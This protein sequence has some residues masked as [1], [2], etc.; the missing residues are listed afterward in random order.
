[1]KWSASDA[2]MKFTGPTSTSDVHTLLV[3]NRMRDA[4]GKVINV[5][6][7]DNPKLMAELK[8]IKKT[9]VDAVDWYEGDYFDIG[10]YDSATLKGYILRIIKQSGLLYAYARWNNTGDADDW[11]E[12]LLR[13]IN[14]SDIEGDGENF[15]YKLEIITEKD[16]RLVIFNLYDVSPDNP[17]IETYPPSVIVTNI[18]VNVLVKPLYMLMSANQN[19]SASNLCQVYIYN[20]KTEVERVK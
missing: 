14:I 13:E 19:S 18:D 6:L 17:V 8:L 12:S 5:P 4:E 16:N 7:T 20:I 11:H 2:W 1:M 3:E 9:G 10:L 15:R